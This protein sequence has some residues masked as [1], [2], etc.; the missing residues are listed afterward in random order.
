ML[1]ET[2]RTCTRCNVPKLL[3]GNYY[4]YKDRNYF[5][6]VC[7]VCHGQEPSQFTAKAKLIASSRRNAKARGLKH[8][9]TQSDLVLPEFCPY[10][11]LKLD[12]EGRERRRDGPSID[13][14]NPAE[15]YVRGNVQ[16]ISD[17]ANKMKS[18]AT[19]EELVAFA[20][21]VL[22]KHPVSFN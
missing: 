4:Y 19:V 12:Y 13:R 15:G 18:D 6:T 14:I 17:L 16:V 22:K 10:L 8:T 11:G 3:I 2:T 21:G 5:M 20:Q 7:K 1:V 9:I